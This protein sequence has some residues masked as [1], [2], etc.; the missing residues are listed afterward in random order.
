MAGGTFGMRIL[1]RNSTPNVD[2]VDENEEDPSVPCSSIQRASSSLV[3]LCDSV[4]VFD[5]FC[6][7]FDRLFVF[8]TSESDVLL[9]SKVRN[10]LIFSEIWEAVGGRA[11]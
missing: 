11:P 10:L 2:N 7:S 9:L 6:D 1:R 8:S 3:Q 5:S 4:T